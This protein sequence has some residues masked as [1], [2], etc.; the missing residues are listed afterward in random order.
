MIEA[1]KHISMELSHDSLAVRPRESGNPDGVSLVSRLRG[2]ERGL[3]LD[4]S[5]TSHRTPW[6]GGLQVRL[7]RS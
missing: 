7:E 2:N 5:K 4:F 1:L 6:I 3:W